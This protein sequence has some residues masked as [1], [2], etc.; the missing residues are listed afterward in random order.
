MIW[1][2]WI[3][4]FLFTM[5]FHRRDKTDMEMPVMVTFLTFLMWPLVLGDDIR[6][7]LS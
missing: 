4:G 1:F 3:I 6:K 5:G 7:T 2:I